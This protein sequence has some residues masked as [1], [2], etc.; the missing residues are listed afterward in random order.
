[1]TV[2][3]PRTSS[4]TPSQAGFPNGRLRLVDNGHN[5]DDY[6][7]T[8]DNIQYR[9]GDKVQVSSSSGWSS[10][11]VASVRR[12]GTY[13]IKFDDGEDVVEPPSCD[14]G[15]GCPLRS[16]FHGLHAA[17]ETPGC[18]RYVAIDGWASVF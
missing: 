9:K 18:S 1:M 11:T 8:G 13:D 2:D 6:N 12:E 15:M 14:G 4:L 17:Q 16:Q 7:P 5:D 3:P 10:G